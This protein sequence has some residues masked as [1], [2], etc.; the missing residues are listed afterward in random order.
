MRSTARGAWGDLVGYQDARHLTDDQFRQIT[1]DIRLIRDIQ[2]GLQANYELM[3]GFAKELNIP[4]GKLP[5]MELI[6]QNLAAEYKPL[7]AS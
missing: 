5:N 3:S 7:L 6:K 4:A 1:K 2:D